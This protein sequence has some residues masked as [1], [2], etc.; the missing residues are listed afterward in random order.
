[1]SSALP[2]PIDLTPKQA[3]FA[4]AYVETGSVKTAY[5]RAYD[6]SRM[7]SLSV[8]QCG[9]ELKREPKVA[10]YIRELRQH[11]ADQSV[12]TVREQLFAL[13]EMAA[14]DLTDLWRIEYRPCA[15][16]DQLRH[17]DFMD[18]RELPDLTQP[19]PPHPLCRDVKAH[20][21]VEMLPMDQ[22]P[23]AA[24]AL[25]D[26]LDMQRD[27]TL[28]PVFR[29]RTALQD[30]LN[31]MLGAYVSRSENITAHVTVDPSKPNPWNA[32]TLTNEQILARVLKSR[33]PV[34]VDQGAT[35]VAQP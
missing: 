14:V 6:T 23:P 35:Q 1:M 4:H 30:Q 32:A 10:A 20:Q 31:R 12:I 17:R 2:A 9:Y 34:T 5:A 25:Y 28:R 11:V 33:P 21:H 27:G 7:K 18:R 24:R 15:A 29:D 19:V 13:A 26:G 3:A 22:W 16:C 8:A